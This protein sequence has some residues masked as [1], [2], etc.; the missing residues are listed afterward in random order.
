MTAP[1]VLFLPIVEWG[2]RV[3]RPH[4]MARYFARAG[5]RV[6]YAGLRLQERP[7]APHLL[8]S[9]IWSLALAGG[10]RFDA[11]RESLDPEAVETALAS[12]AGRLARDWLERLWVVVQ[13][14]GWRALGEAVR[15]SF[16]GVL[17][18]DCMD[19]FAAF[20]DHGDLRAE[21]AALAAAADLV[22]VS[23]Q[24][25]HDR[26]APLNPRTRLVHNGCDPEHFA[27]AGARRRRAV[28]VVGF[29]G[30]IHEWFDT[31]LV[32]ALARLRP[33]W[34][35]WLVGDTYGA[36]VDELRRQPNL[37]LFGEA[38]YDSL[39]R[40]ASEFDVGIVPFRVTPLTRAADPVKVYEMLAAGLPVV[41]SDLPELR[42]LAPH[43]AVA[44]TAEQFAAAI[45]AALGEP[46]EAAR[47]RR[48]FAADQSWSRRFAELRRALEETRPPAPPSDPQP[49]STLG[50]LG[51][52][53]PAVEA[54]E[55][56]GVVAA[57][58]EQRASL[59]EQ[60]D[61]VEAENR[62]L[63][64]ELLRAQSEA[65]RPAWTG[66]RIA[67]RLRRLLGRGPG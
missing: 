63:R 50:D 24:L 47:R 64:A 18:F 55:L 11:Y 58:E 51:A 57:L 62:R 4:H 27:P 52:L 45:E 8:E 17:L 39:P 35:F 46:P 65:Q 13:L 34:R 59:I 21:E 10:P 1:T 14:P 49:A 36:R 54:R 42:R 19:D 7:A 41:G 25:L 53:P 6:L 15:R 30:G 32:A 33:E 60:R 40:I 61:R 44:S 2:F 43:V 48:A 29:F 22:S 37:T 3:Q 28:P 23:S 9:G 56:R 20:E 67:R 38:A 5:H 66:A 26:L 31:E 12:L 16:D